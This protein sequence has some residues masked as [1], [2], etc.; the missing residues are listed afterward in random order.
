VPTNSYFPYFKGEIF[1][2]IFG[3]SVNA[4]KNKKDEKKKLSKIRYSSVEL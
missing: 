4:E 3:V 2:Q 1:S